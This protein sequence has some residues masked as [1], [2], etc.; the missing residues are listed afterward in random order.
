MNLEQ[1]V[2][3]KH[4]NNEHW[5]VEEVNTVANQQR[6]MNVEAKKD[7]L[8]G[9]HKI[10]N[11]PSFMYNGERITP[12]KIVLNTAKTLLQFHIQFLLKNDVVLTG[13]EKM[14]DE[15]NKVN[16]L[17]KYNAKNLKILSNLLKFGSCAEYVFVNKKGYIDSK[18]IPA[19]EGTPIY[20]HH[21]EMIAF[22][23]SY[24]FDGISY[25]TLYE[26]DVVKEYNNEGGSMKLSAQY[27]NLSG[28]PIHYHS[29]NEYS[30]IEG[31]SVLDDFI[32]I[33]DNMELLLSKTVD[34]TYTHFQGI[35][36]ITGQRLTTGGIP[37]ELVSGGVHLD[38]GST[39]DFKSNDL[40]I[41]AFEALYNQLNQSLLDVSGTPAVSMNK[42]DISNLSEVSITMLFGLAEVK[43]SE[44]ESYIREGMMERYDKI[45]K[46][47]SF[48]GV[49]ITDEQYAS[50][51]LLFKY[52]RPSNESERV[53]DL[54]ELRLLNGISLESMLEHSPYTTDVSMEL[55]R[56]KAESNQI[57]PVKNVNEIVE[58]DNALVK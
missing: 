31:S 54:K 30:D 36:V 2:K 18:I 53:K 56:L 34:A 43:A 51:S 45:R 19:D 25:Y 21:N 27:A 50:L 47:L 20:N 52:N 41:K 16:K 44:N 1:Y 42:S 12:R 57:K 32:I 37:K 14:I 33:L 49:T 3:A 13:N 17:G 10:Q 28:L 22:V 11:L 46:L 4:R 29:H 8:M 26:D 38:D 39:F 58:E 40:D 15:L 5:F 7:Y 24:V 55:G 6:L 9:N 23:Q 35:P 48:R